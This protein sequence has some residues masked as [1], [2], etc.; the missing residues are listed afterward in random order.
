MIESPDGHQLQ[1]TVSG[2]WSPPSPV[3][4]P[5]RRWLLPASLRWRNGLDGLWI[6]DP[7]QTFRSLFL[8][9]T[10]Q[11]DANHHCALLCGRILQRAGADLRPTGPASLHESQI[12]GGGRGYNQ[13]FGK[14]EKK[15]T[16]DKEVTTR[17]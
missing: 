11:T 6:S 15:K 14:T 2:Y 8:K 13:N 7:Q 3:A 17:P 5:P 16:E 12:V 9:L 10:I 4:Q 1:Q